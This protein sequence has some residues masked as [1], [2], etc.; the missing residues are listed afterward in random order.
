MFDTF[1]WPVNIALTQDQLTTFNWYMNQDAINVYMSDIDLDIDYGNAP[2]GT[3]DDQLNPPMPA[4]AKTPPMWGVGR[5]SSSQNDPF[6]KQ[7]IGKALYGIPH[8][9]S[10]ANSDLQTVLGGGAGTSTPPN[11]AQGTYTSN[12]IGRTNNFVTVIA[13]YTNLYSYICGYSNLTD[14]TTTGYGLA[15][16]KVGTTSTAIDQSYYYKNSKIIG[17]GGTL[18][19]WMGQPGAFNDAAFYTDGANTEMKQ[20]DFILDGNVKHAIWSVLLARQNQLIGRLE[21][22]IVATL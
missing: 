5:G 11:G 8:N 20:S 15:N 16:I 1:I 7:T 19:K 12:Q 22:T 10:K 9:A 14:S 21:P 3:V 4:N 2:S 18:G 13:D 17:T 6:I